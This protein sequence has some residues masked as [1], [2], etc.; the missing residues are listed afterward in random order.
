[1]RSGGWASGYN[2]PV[3]GGS[4]AGAGASDMAEAN[5]VPPLRGARACVPD[6]GVC[7]VDEML[8]VRLDGQGGWGV[9]GMRNGECGVAIPIAIPMGRD[10]NLVLR[11]LRN[12]GR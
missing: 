9:G 6:G 11:V 4:G 8:G 1:M 12:G 3:D 5:G 10:L 2:S 7:S